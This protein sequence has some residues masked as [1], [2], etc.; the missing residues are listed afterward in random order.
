MAD[1]YTIEGLGVATQMFMEFISNEYV[2]I[3]FVGVDNHFFT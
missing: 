1:Y 2:Y 3:K